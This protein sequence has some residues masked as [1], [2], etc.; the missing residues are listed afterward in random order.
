VRD[1]Q[2][3]GR[4][5]PRRLR[6]LLLDVDDTLY[7]TTAFARRARESS[8]RA[9]IDA[10]LALPFE[11]VMAE[12]EEVVGEFPSNY[13]RHY[14]SL[15]VRLPASALGRVNPAVVIASGV[16]AY[17]Q[18]KMRELSASSDALEVLRLLAGRRGLLLGAVTSGVPVK[19][20]EK[21]VRLGVLKH[22]DPGG[23]F[24]AEQMGYSKHNP[25]LY[26]QVS[27]ILGF[28]P[29]ECMTVGDHPVRDVD[30][31]RRA[32]LL[33]VLYRGG[34]KYQ[35]EQGET[36]PDYVIQNFWDLM[37]ILD[38]DFETGVPGPAG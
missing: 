35:Y 34:G 37:E 31:P 9:M 33:T 32:G 29:G 6:A 20:A 11:T 16:V 7:S 30:S 12:L 8:V 1:D 38:R 18:T 23:I 13:D 25:K 17:H 21:L 19:Q 14:D 15:L 26:S 2:A 27:R 3:A 10:G 28:Q 24:F 36:A 5:R 4:S 22:L